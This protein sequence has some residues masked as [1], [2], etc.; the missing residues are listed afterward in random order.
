[1]AVTTTQLADNQIIVTVE[2]MT[3]LRN[4]KNAI[5]LIR[6]VKTVQM[7]KARRRKT[8]LDAALED[9]KAGRVYH[10]KDVD[11]LFKQCLG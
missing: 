9:I 4:I 3:L 11:D 2:D 6:G 7:P 5:S 10:A 8:G 1:M